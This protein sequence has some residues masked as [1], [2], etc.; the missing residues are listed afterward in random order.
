ML[1][2]QTDPIPHVSPEKRH[3]HDDIGWATQLLKY[4][5]DIPPP[6]T[7]SRRSA[8]DEIE[9]YFLDPTRVSSSL[10]LYWQVRDLIYYCTM[11]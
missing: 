3:R 8:H 7:A 4:G 5:Y 1:K 11:V 6:T 10:V 9:A 2:Y